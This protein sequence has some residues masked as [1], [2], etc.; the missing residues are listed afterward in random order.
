ESLLRKDEYMLFADYQTYIDCQERVNQAYRNPEY[1]TRMSIINSINMGKFSA[2]RTINEYCQEI[3][4]VEPV[5]ID[6][7]AYSQ[8]TAGLQRYCQI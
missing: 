6:M 4:N 7:E 2:D 5:K 1:W 3:W 8:E